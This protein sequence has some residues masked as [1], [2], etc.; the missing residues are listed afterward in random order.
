MSPVIRKVVYRS[1]DDTEVTM[2]LIDATSDR[3]LPCPVIM[4]AYGGFGISMSPQ[5]SVLITVMLELGFICAVPEIRGGGE[6]GAQWAEAGRSRNRQNAFDDFIS[7]TQWLCDNGIASPTKLCVF[8]ACNGGLLVGAVI[9]QCPAL[10]RAALC[11][12]PLLDMI[13]YETFDRARF[14]RHEYGTTSDPQDF[15]ALYAYSPYHRIEQDVDYPA[16]MFVAGDKDT[17]ANPAHTFKMV[18]RMQ[19]RPAQVH[20]ILLDY[21]KERGH[22][23]AMPTSVRVESIAHRIAFLCSEL[24]ISFMPGGHNRN[25]TRR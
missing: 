23:P 3:L 15:Q 9:T 20:R 12:A 4:T 17:R 21:S 2:S 16:V 14:W 13:R 5:F 25:E 8:G 22:S 6:K 24:G 19:E 18:A 11:I 10:F 1:K 7:G